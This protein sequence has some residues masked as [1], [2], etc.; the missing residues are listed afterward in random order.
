M[1]RSDGPVVRAACE[2]S[3][4]FAA[5][6]ARLAG[7]R[8]KSLVYSQFRSVE[9]IGILELVLKANG[10]SRFSL[11]SKGAA[12]YDDIKK[13]Q[14]FSFDSRESSRTLIH[15][16][17]GEVDKVPEPLRA[18]VALK[19]PDFRV[20][21]VS[22]S[23]AEGL[24]L[25]EVRQVLITEPYWNEIRIQQVIGRA[26]R[27]ESHD[28]LPKKDRVVDVYRYLASIDCVERC[29]DLG[30]GAERGADIRDIPLPKSMRVIERDGKRF[31]NDPETDTDYDYAEWKSTGKR[32]KVSPK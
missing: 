30:P 20:L 3:P 27:L 6:L 25:K 26:A 10:F 23:G 29:H 31:L 22:A 16:Y 18:F 19:K 1:G 14:F 12:V 13:P 8:K 32:V 21:F 7:E 11:D 24:N 28:K 15:L 5:I 9:G 4:K 2:L 17:N